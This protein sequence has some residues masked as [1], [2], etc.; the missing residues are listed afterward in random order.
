[1][2]NVR[3][4]PQEMLIGDGAGDRRE[5]KNFFGCCR[6]WFKCP[7]FWQSGG[8]PTDGQTVIHLRSLFSLLSLS[9]FRSPIKRDAN[10]SVSCLNRN[11]ENVTVCVRVC[12]K[13]ESWYVQNG[14]WGE[15]IAP[16][17]SYK[18]TTENIPGSRE[19]RLDKKNRE[20]NVSVLFRV[21]SSWLLWLVSPS[22]FCFDLLQKAARICHF[23]VRGFL[24]SRNVIQ[25]PPTVSVSHTRTTLIY[26][27]M[28]DNTPALGFFKTFPCPEFFHSLL[29]DVV[30]L[31]QCPTQKSRDIP[32]SPGKANK[33]NPGRF[34][35]KDEL[36][37]PASFWSAGLLYTNGCPPRKKR[38]IME[39]APSCIANKRPSAS[40]T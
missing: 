25:L 2:R 4:M 8:R 18:G 13:K 30:A 10:S 6:E 40:P 20:T 16:F 35:R 28:R 34:L 22:L 39:S 26:R 38:K 9:L 14:K 17:S 7:E 33:K 3:K 24:G 36:A 12:V 21:S 11:S 37:I 19:R 32:N 15:A 31:F 29:S 27:G 1:M 23:K 5:K